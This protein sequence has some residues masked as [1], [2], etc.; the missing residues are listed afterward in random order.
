[1]PR[2][3][4]NA[5]AKPRDNKGP[6]HLAFERLQRVA[7]ACRIRLSS[8]GHVPTWYLKRGAEVRWTEKYV[9]ISM[10]HFY[11]YNVKTERLILWL[12]V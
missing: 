1:M 3:T 7:G 4:D 8:A 10:K 12:H 2:T 5:T 9:L 6:E 11:T